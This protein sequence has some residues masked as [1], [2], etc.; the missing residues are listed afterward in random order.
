MQV[1]AHPASAWTYS[2]SAT[3][4]T[5]SYCTKGYDDFLFLAS[6]Q[7]LLSGVMDVL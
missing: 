2:N 1:Q 3:R 5:L 4:Y 7:T 6:F